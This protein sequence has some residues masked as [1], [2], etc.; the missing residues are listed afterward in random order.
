M[1]NNYSNQTYEEI[2]NNAITICERNNYSQRI[3]AKQQQLLFNIAD[4]E[5][6]LD[7]LKFDALRTVN[8]LQ[9]VYV[10]TNAINSKF[11]DESIELLKDSFKT[12]KDSEYTDDELN[13]YINHVEVIILNSYEARK[14]FTEI[15]NKSNLSEVTGIKELIE[16]IKLIKGKEKLHQSFIEECDQKIRELENDILKIENQLY[17]NDFKILFR[18]FDD[19]KYH[20]ISIN[21]FEGYLVNDEVLFCTSPFEQEID[22]LIKKYANSHDSKM[23]IVDLSKLSLLTLDSMKYCFS[24]IFKENDGKVVLVYRNVET[25]IKEKSSLEKLRNQIN[26]IKEETDVTQFIT[27]CD[28]K[29]IDELIKGKFSEIKKIICP[30]PTYEELCFQLEKIINISDEYTFIKTYCYCLGYVALNKIMMSGKTD[31][32]DIKIQIKKV[33]NKNAKAFKIFAE[34]LLYLPDLVESK[35]GYSTDRPIIKVDL[36]RKTTKNEYDYDVVPEFCLE[37]LKLILENDEI[38]EFARCGLA[39]TYAIT[40][41]EDDN[42]F[43]ELSKEEKQDRIKLACN[44]L[45][46]ILKVTQPEVEFVS[47]SKVTFYGLNIGGGTKMQFS[48]AIFK[49]VNTIIDTILHEFYHSVQHQASKDIQFYW[50]NF[51]ITP[52]RIEVWKEN[53]NFYIAPEGTAIKHILNQSVDYTSECYKLY[54]NQIMEG[55]ARIFAADCVEHAAQYKNLIYMKRLD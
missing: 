23:I 25:I 1:N 47:K 27:S 6:V 9:A 53:N 36:N 39:V 42:L 52:K 29:I 38:S 16:K 22:F 49:D 13:G 35:W 21:P 14:E 12:I 8:A 46:Q 45:A 44:I 18:E 33:Y 4:E 55:D 41:F 15:I 17:S 31:I 28:N 20:N 26:I 48:D 51:S 50:D 54:A 11:T 30:M 32:D 34:T 7:N 10:Y 43:Y 37:K 24:R 40:V 2:I 19:F 3:V 5:G